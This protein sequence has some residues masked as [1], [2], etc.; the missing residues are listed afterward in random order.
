[1][2][3][4]FLSFFAEDKHDQTWRPSDEHDRLLVILRW[5]R[6]TERLSGLQ[7]QELIFIGGSEMEE[8]IIV[9]WQF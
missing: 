9:S 1:M 5:N 6:L 3:I 8:E 4:P 7:R 2:F